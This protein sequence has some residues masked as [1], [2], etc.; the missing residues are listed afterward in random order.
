[1]HTHDLRRLP[2]ASTVTPPGKDTLRFPFARN[3]PHTEKALSGCHTTPAGFIS[4]L[5]LPADITPPARSQ[6]ADTTPRHFPA[7]QP[8]NK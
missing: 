7:K 2:C 5:F 8:A 6:V 1:V 4:F 3:R